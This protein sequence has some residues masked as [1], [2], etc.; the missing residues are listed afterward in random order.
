MEFRV[1]LY[2]FNT[3]SIETLFISIERRADCE[4]RL[5]AFAALRKQ[6]KHKAAIFIRVGI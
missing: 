3:S 2:F 1:F 6:V 5:F 4:Y